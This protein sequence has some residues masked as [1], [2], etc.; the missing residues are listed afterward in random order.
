[1]E[2]FVTSRDKT[3]LQVDDSA[4]TVMWTDY[5][6]WEVK[7]QHIKSIYFDDGDYT[8][9]VDVNVDG[10]KENHLTELP[11]PEYEAVKLLF[12]ENLDGVMVHLPSRKSQLIFP[13][14][15]IALIFILTGV[16]AFFSRES[17]LDTVETNSIDWFMNCCRFFATYVGIPK[18]LIGG[19][20]MVGLL[21]LVVFK[22]YFFTKQ[23]TKVEFHYGD[24]MMI[25]RSED[26]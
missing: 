5:P 4:I 14:I 26:T 7:A 1:M 3:T 6:V 2:R 21:S 12:T 22:R 9:E 23:A 19:G 11:K 25:F 20:I 8:M 15:A 13:L 17:E 18:I 24:R 16:L 10:E